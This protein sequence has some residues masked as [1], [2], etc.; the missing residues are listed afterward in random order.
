MKLDQLQD[1]KVWHQRHWRHQPLEKHAWDVVL[2]LWLAGC[3]GLPSA[4][5]THAPWG[6]AVCG[7]LL[8]LPGGYVRLRTRL[9]RA[10]LLRCDWIAALR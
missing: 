4:L 5:L 10:G 2:T 9:H 8:F 3:V 7:A 1:L 6:S